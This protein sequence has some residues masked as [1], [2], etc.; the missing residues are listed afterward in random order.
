MS[1]R[2]ML[3]IER[4]IKDIER[5]YDIQLDSQYIEL[6][7]RPLCGEV[8]GGKCRDKYCKQK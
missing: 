8:C 7:K 1:C 6:L 3:Y 5:Q 4:V 2:L